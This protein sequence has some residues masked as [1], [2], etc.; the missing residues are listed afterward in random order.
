LFPGQQEFFKKNQASS[1][2]FIYDPVTSCKKS[3]K[4]MKVFREK[5]VT[6]GQT[7]EGTNERS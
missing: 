2:L 1:L 4:L 7:D 6:N 5:P 3:E